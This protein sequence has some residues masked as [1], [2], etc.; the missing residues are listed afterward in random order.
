M[1]QIQEKA[2][3]RTGFWCRNLS[4]RDHLKDL[5]RD[6]RIILK[7]ILKNSDGRAWTGLIW[8]RIEPCGRLCESDTETSGSTK[9]GKFLDCL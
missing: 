6:G 2:D 3:L 9:C 4:E 5:S 7:W 1:S 8:L